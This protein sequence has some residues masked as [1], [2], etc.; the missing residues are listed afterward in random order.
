MRE[1]PARQSAAAA[2][3]KNRDATPQI[4]LL[5]STPVPPSERYS[6]AKTP[7][8][9]QQ[10]NTDELDEAISQTLASSQKSMVESGLLKQPDSHHLHTQS[11]ASSHQ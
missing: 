2:T 11:Q 7:Q 6:E 9:A 5:T 8:I 3:A 10:L 4:A 1:T